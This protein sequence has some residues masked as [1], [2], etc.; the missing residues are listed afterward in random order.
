MS[1]KGVHLVF[2][3]ASTLLALV[4]AVWCLQ[5]YRATENL[6][7]LAVGLGCIVSAVVLVAYGSWFTRNKLSRLP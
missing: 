4:S 6:T 1:L 2:I 3:T 5:Q 7:L